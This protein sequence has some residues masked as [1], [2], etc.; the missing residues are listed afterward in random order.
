MYK[1]DLFREYVDGKKENSDNNLEARNYRSLTTVLNPVL[2]IP[3]S[4]I[5]KKCGSLSI[6]ESL[7]FILGN[8]FGFICGVMFANLLIIIIIIPINFFVS[9]FA[10][11]SMAYFRN[12]KPRSYLRHKIW[13]TGMFKNVFFMKSIFYDKKKY[14]IYGP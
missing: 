7:V 3:G 11:F 2:F 12:K 14:T 1:V 13:Q 8:V 9:Y 5:F 10:S 6:T 4:W